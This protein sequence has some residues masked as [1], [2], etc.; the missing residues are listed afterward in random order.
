VEEKY[1]EKHNKEIKVLRSD[2]GVE[3]KSD[4]FLKLY[5]NEGIERYFIVRETLQQNKVAERM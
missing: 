2:N 3:Y 4:P 1:R 5:P